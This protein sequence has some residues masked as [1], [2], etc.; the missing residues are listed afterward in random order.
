M[1]HAYKVAVDPS[2]NAWLAGQTLSANFPLVAPIQ[3]TLAGSGD[4]FVSKIATCGATL[5]PSGTVFGAA[6][7]G[8][9]LSIAT[10][11]ECSWSISSDSP[12]LVVTPGSEPGQARRRIRW[13]QIP[14][15]LLVP[16]FTTA[17]TSAVIV[18]SGTAATLTSIAPSTGDSGTS[19]TVTLNGNNLSPVPIVNA[20]PHISVSNINVVSATQLTA[21]FTIAANAA[22]AV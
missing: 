6:G 8:G 12:W 17:G 15:E 11:S 21:T 14:R 13:R 16:E 1:D 2:G 9:N 3:G 4:V 22:P 18:Q 19:A 20:G 7:G 5:S 10:S